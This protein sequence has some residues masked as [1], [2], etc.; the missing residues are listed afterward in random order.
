MHRFNNYSNLMPQDFSMQLSCCRRKD[1]FFFSFISD[2]STYLFNRFADFLWIYRVCQP[3]LLFCCTTHTTHRSCQ[4]SVPT[5]SILL[6][7]L[8]C[9]CRHMQTRV[10]IHRQAFS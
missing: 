6:L 3:K 5:F 4:W 8:T 1:N 9:S 2:S 10:S 7:R